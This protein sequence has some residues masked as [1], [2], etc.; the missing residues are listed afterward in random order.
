MAEKLCINCESLPQRKRLR[1]G[2]C[3]SWLHR[4]GYDRPAEVIHAYWLRMLEKAG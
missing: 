3:A 1:C 4:H 2:P